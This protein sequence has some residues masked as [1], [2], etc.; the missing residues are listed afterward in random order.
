MKILVINSGSSSIKYQL[1]E[2]PGSTAVA[3]GLVERIGEPAGRVLYWSQAG[4]R[5]EREM[6]IADH[7]QGLTQVVELLLDGQDGVIGS[8]G[9]ITAVGHRVVHGGEKFS[10]PTV[11]DAEVMDTIRE[12]IPLAPLHNPANLSGIEVAREI[13]PEAAQVAVF[14]TAFHQTMPPRAYRYAIPNALYEEQHIRVYGFH[15]TSHL[16]VS[17]MAMAHLGKPAAD[18]NLISIHLGNG[19][20]MT[21]VAGGKSIDTTMGFSPLPGLIMGTRSGDIDPAVIFYLSERLEMSVPEIDRLLN[22][23]SGLLGLTGANDVRDIQ[24]RREA[25]DAAATLALEMYAYRVKKYIGAYTAVLGRVDAVIFTAGVG[26]NSPAVR[27]L[28]CANMESLGIVLDEAK[29][30]AGAT[31]PVTEI[32][33]ENGRVKILIIPT[34]EEREIASQTYALV[35]QIK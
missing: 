6:P 27:R 28:V 23:Q 30:A 32:Q 35:G 19:A 7:R 13:F 4:A 34:N 16:Y 5:V 11:I 15:G 33:G 9:E 20:S 8:A 17:K 18:T 14:D 2:M 26:Q 3:G 29:N 24:A 1:F 31:G 25:G 22:K 10:Q 21:A 12:L